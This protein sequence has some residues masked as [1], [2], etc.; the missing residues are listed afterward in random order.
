MAKAAATAA[1]TAFPPALSILT[2]ASDASGWAVE[3]IPFLPEK[4]AGVCDCS[5]TAELTTR[6]IRVEKIFLFILWNV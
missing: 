2:A 4:G 1:S 6:V 5:T 3:A